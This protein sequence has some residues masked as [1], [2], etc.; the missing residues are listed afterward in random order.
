MTLFPSLTYAMRKVQ[1]NQQGL[2][3]SVTH[4]LLVSADGVDLLGKDIDTIKKNTEVL[5]FISKHT[6]LEASTE[7][8]KSV[9]FLSC[10]WNTRQNPQQQRQVINPLKMC[11]M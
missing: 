8:I 7:K 10:K 5:L 2:K 1:A 6:G 4:Q 3:W 11:E 9:F